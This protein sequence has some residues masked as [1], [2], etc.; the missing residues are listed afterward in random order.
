MTALR[1]NYRILIE[2]N[3]NS[4]LAVHKE[5]LFSTALSRPSACCLGPL[6]NHIRDRPGTYRILGREF[7]TVAPQRFQ[8]VEGKQWWAVG[9]ETSAAIVY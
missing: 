6:L 2:Y 7:T 3:N 5:R 9:V 1:C 8:L 4:L